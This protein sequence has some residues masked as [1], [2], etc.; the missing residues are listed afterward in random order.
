MW[1]RAQPRPKDTA[2]Y[3]CSQAAETR[4]L[5]GKPGVAAQ[6]GGCNAQSYRMESKVGM[7]GEQR[8]L[9]CRLILLFLR[10]GRVW[11]GGSALL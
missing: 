5:V 1:E 9:R 10:R 7:H 6:C 3:C 4:W 11:R 8:C 2:S